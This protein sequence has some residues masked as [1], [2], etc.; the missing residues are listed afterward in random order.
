MTETLP[1]APGATP[2]L[3]VPSADTAA[4]EASPYVTFVDCTTGFSSDEV[5]DADREIVYFDSSLQAMV[6]AASGDRVG[7]WTVAGADLDWS[8]SGVNFRV[9][10]GS[11]AGERRAYFTEAGPGTIC[12]LNVAGPDVLFIS[13]TSETPPN[14]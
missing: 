10:F 1:L 2:A 7:G 8:Q 11:E 4:S 14:P 5:F 13:G 12:D 9:R 3:P 6:S